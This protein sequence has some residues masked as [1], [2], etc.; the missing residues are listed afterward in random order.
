MLLIL[1]MYAL[2]AA[3][4]PL[5]KLALR[6]TNPFFLETV[7]MMVG[8]T[9]LLTYYFFRERSFFVIRRQDW[10][11]FVQLIIF[12]MYLS[13][14]ASSWALQYITSLKANLLYSLVPFVSA[15][16]GY[17]LLREKPSAQKVVGMTVGMSG[18]LLILLSAERQVAHWGD[19]MHI[20]MPEVMMLISIF[21]TEYGYFLLKR[22][23]DKG[24]SLLLINGV[25][26][27]VG[28]SLSLLSA[29]LFFQVE[30]MSYTKFSSVLFYAAL[31][32]SLI[33]VVDI[34]FYGKLIKK[35]SVTFLTFA[36]FLS[37]IF[38]VLYGTIFMGEM[39]SFMHLAAFGLIFLGLY[40]F[41]RDESGA[42][43]ITTHNVE[44]G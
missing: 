7:R 16:F 43:K 17:L 37:P 27:F 2:F 8:G 4:F 9:A 23:Y 41:L 18:L 34:I 6:E 33:N 5:A 19:C 21:S 10:Q 29:Y 38:G 13:Y 11:L 1:C 15:G 40:L 14:F 35:Y 44:L 3:E 39:I 32:F 24:Y 36:S 31:L 20:T 28:G 30:V 26:M 22:L 12:Y 25:S 42:A